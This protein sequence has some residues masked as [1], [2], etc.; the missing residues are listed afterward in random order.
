[1]FNLSFPSADG[2]IQTLETLSEDAYIFSAPET[3]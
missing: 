3:Y 2:F 1:M